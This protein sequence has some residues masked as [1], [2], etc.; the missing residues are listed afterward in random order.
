METNMV[1]ILP[2]SLKKMPPPTH[3]GAAFMKQIL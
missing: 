2:A 3:P 1:I